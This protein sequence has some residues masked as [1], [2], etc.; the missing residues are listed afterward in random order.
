MK[1][2]Y[3]SHPIGGS[4]SENLSDLYRIIRVIN[5]TM[6]DVVPFAPYVADI[7]AM[8]DNIPAE[9][10]RGIANDIAILRSGIVQ[11]LWLTGPRISTGMQH[12]KELAIELGIPVIDMIGKL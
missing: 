9:R 8:D 12:E 2:C 5:L 3:V 11:E 7:L 6:S 4:I 1:I 10:E